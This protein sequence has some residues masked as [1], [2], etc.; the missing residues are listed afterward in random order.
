MEQRK[1]KVSF[2]TQREKDILHLVA[3]CYGYQAIQIE[4]GIS[5]RTMQ[6]EVYRLMKKVGLHKKEQLILYAQQN[7]Y[8]EATSA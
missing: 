7:G 1:R 2:P 4:L 3:Q 5:R 8:G 6:N